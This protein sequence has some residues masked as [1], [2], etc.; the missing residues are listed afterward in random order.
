MWIIFHN[1]LSCVD[2]RLG[3]IAF[4]KQFTE[5][6]ACSDLYLFSEFMQPFVRVYQV[7][8]WYGFTV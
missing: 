5:N 2:S 8:F 1:L 3:K 7:H 6:D 4:C